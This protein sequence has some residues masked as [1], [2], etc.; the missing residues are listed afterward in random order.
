VVMR[1]AVTAGCNCNDASGF[2]D[3]DMPMIIWTRNPRFCPTSMF[4]TFHVPQNLKPH[5]F[6]QVCHIDL[7]WMVRSTSPIL[8]R[9]YGSD[10]RRSSMGGPDHACT[11]CACWPWPCKNKRAV[12]I[13]SGTAAAFWS[14]APTMTLGSVRQRR[15]QQSHVEK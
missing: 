2:A 14:I 6:Q 5:E 15:Q 13:R 9:S 4:A 1:S 10:F 12:S 3:S 11:C 7:A 8:V